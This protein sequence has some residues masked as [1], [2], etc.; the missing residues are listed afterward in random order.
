MV[1]DNRRDSAYLFGAI[2][3]ERAVGAAI[4]MP[5]VTRLFNAM[6]WPAGQAGCRVAECCSV[7]VLGERADA[8][9]FEDVEGE[10]AQAGGD[11]GI[12]ADAR[13][14]LP[15]RH[16][17]A[18][19]GGRLDAPVRADRLGGAGGGDGCVGDLACGFGGAVQQAGLAA[20]GEHL[21]LD[22]DDGG[23]VGLP[24]GVGEGLRGGKDADG[25]AFVAV[26]AGIVAAGGIER[27]GGG[28]D[29]GAGLMQGRLV[30]V[31]LHDQR[32]VG[33]GGD[34]EDGVDGSQ[35]HRCAMLRVVTTCSREP[36]AMSISM[37]GLDTAKSVFQ[38]HA[39]DTGGNAVMRRKVQRDELIRFFEKQETCTVVMEA[40]GAAH[41]WARMLTTLGHDVKLIAPEAVR[42]FV[43][44]GQKNDAADA[45]AICEAASRPDM[46]F[47]PVKRLEQQG[48]LALHSARSL[49]VK[50]QTMLA[51][52]MRGLATEFG[53][54]VPKG[55]GKLDDL[56][57][58]VE[59]DEA[60]P[61]NARQ[62]FTGLLEHRRAAAET[63]KAFEAEIVAHARH[64]DT[65]RRLATIPGVGRS[66][67]P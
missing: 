50:Q 38:V 8:V 22:L 63:I 21:A 37:I 56:V 20:A 41:H 1:H 29:L 45:A 6:R 48:I 33:L 51:N 43:K 15:H 39:L 57:A 62:V 42:P 53:L 4:I 16:V 44:K 32:D 14:I 26:A 11:S 55:I 34:V 23:D 46:R 5:T 24:V 31:E 61:E 19:V 36:P 17:A 27:R 40:C 7:A 28:D 2:C 47:V 59:T 58:L 3:P 64:D 10:A 12:G 66:P 25:A 54:T 35:R 18:V 52:A 67:R 13:A 60:F 65:A 49:L 9:G 30:V